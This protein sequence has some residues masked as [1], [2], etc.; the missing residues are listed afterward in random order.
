MAVAVVLAVPLGVW[1]GH[2]HRGSFIAINAANVG[3]AL[4]SLAVIAIGLSVFGFGFT[5]VLVA[6]VILAVPPILTNAYVAVDEVGVEAARGMGMTGWQALRRVELPLALPLLFAGIRTAAVFVVASATIAAIAGEGEPTSRSSTRRAT[7]RKAWSGRRSSSRCSP[8]PRTS[9]SVAAA[10][11]DALACA[12]EFRPSSRMS[13]SHEQGG[14]GGRETQQASGEGRVR[15]RARSRSRPRRGRRR[16][17]ARTGRGDPVVVGAKNFTEQ[18]VL[19]QLYKQALEARGL[20]VAYKENIGSTE[21]AAK[22]LTSGQIT[23]YPEYT[24]VMLSVTFGRKTTP[25]PRS[26]PTTWRTLWGKRGYALGRQ[27]PFQDRDAI[28]V[29]R[30]TA[31]R[32]GL[33]TIGDLRKVPNLSLAAFRRFGRGTSAPTAVRSG[34]RRRT[35][36]NV[37]FKP[38]AGISAYTLLNRGDVQAAGIFTTDPQLIARSTS[39]CAIRATCSGSS[40]SRRS[41]RRSSSPRTRRC[42]RPWVSRLLTLQ[43]DDRDEQGSRNRQ[44]AAGRGRLSVPEAN[45]LS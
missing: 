9:R 25:S 42:C 21:I 18:Y 1:L 29:L 41:C 45:G 36:S 34:C 8:S 13:S 7:G 15:R 26:R 40:T 39:S 17:A 43:G 22:A 16:A 3:R 31:T 28:A 30:S 24:G 35:G 14:K 2:L 32:F 5:N 12:P 27:T 20:R 33:K 23:L 6:L 11:V 37:D 44:E 19:G 10:R 38:L 4:P